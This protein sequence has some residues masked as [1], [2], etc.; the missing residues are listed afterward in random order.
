MFND[1]MR[2]DATEREINKKISSIFFR[3]E[4]ALREKNQLGQA[5]L[6]EYLGVTSMCIS[7]WE[8]GKNIP[9]NLDDV[10]KKV[11]ELFELD[12]GVLVQ[13][14]FAERYNPNA[15]KKAKKDR[16]PAEK[17]D[18]KDIAIRY[19]NSML[20]ESMT[21]YLELEKEYNELRFKIGGYKKAL[22]LLGVN[23]AIDLDMKEE[24]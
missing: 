5:A 15:Y 14:D 23:A 10:I 24:N 22:E 17:L 7:N 1:G 12:P 19:I 16:Q 13:E 4:K 3:N 21:K 9:E 18:D 20:E 6:G 11:A 2:E 8:L